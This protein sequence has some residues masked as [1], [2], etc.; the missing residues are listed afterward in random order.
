MSNIIYV[1]FC[2]VKYNNK[3]NKLLDLYLLWNFLIRKYKKWSIFI[4]NFDKVES[5][6]WFFR[7]FI[8]DLLLDF[9]FSEILKWKIIILWWKK[10]FCIKDKF[11]WKY[12]YIYI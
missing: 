10:C 8:V 1:D 6:F 7:L 12:Y 5:K 3:I 9:T 11:S 2:L 4:N